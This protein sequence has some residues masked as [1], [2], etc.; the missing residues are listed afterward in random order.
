VTARITP[1]ELILEP[2]E[3][4][5]FPAI[6]A[7]AEQRGTDTRRRDQ[8]LLLGHVGATLKEMVPDD[9]PTEALDEYGEL[10][11]QGFQ[12]WDFGRRLY[13]FDE[14]VTARLTAP[15][16]D[17]GDWVLAAPPACYIQLPYQRLW[18][19]VATEA[20]YEPVDGFF[21]VVDDTAPAP[22]AG[23]H[24]RAQLI[25]GFRR[26]RPGLSLVS[27]RTDLDPR[28]AARHARS[29]WREDAPP[30]ESAIPGGERRGYKTLATTSELEALALRALHYLDTH[31][32]AL[33][34]EEGSAEE[35]ASHLAHVI[36]REG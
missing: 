36:V 32:L 10:L 20:P 28:R 5:D 24:L 34:A 8:F 6:R 4:T 1:Y 21:M 7:E 12:F 3:T 19:R 18:A 22:E 16:Y 13:V 35:G 27:Y 23:A 2:L 33:V 30:F 29:P 17:F 25:L 9:A 26:D 15:E 14:T 31:P 11:Y